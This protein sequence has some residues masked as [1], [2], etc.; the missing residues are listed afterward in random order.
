MYIW[1]DAIFKI[2]GKLKLI[3]NNQYL[4]EWEGGREQGG[5]KG[6]DYKMSW[7]NFWTDGYFHCLGYGDGFRGIYTI[8]TY[9]IVL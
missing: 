9:Q 1:K 2:S 7:G 4:L 5:V 6:R 3:Y 8:K